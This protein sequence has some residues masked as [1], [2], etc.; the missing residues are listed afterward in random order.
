MKVGDGLIIT[1]IFRV[2]AIMV[3]LG[4]EGKGIEGGN[5][6][7]AQPGLVGPN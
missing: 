6:S 5:A 2:F 4:E 7:H 1:C 3:A